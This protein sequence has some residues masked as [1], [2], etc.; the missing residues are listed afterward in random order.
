M[1]KIERLKKHVKENKAVY[2]KTA[3]GV[4][5]G[6]VIGAFVFPRKSITNEQNIRAY[7]ANKFGGYK[8]TN[9]TVQT[10]SMYG[11]VIG[12]PGN[13]VIDLDTMREYKSQSL[14]AISAGVSNTSM[15]RHLNGEYSEVN[16]R[17]FARILEEV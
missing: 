12:R 10:I 17:R 1:D 13:R 7:F 14:A 6:M 11:N 16:G 5:V 9:N 8:P 4:A 3:A 15:W 2:I